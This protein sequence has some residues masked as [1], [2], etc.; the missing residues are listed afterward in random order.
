M[1][2]DQAYQALYIIVLLAF[3]VMIGI[4]LIR[5]V[6]TKGVMERILCVNMLSTMVI[7]SIA[8][9]ARM[10]REPFL[11]DV[12]LIY[13]MISFVAVLMLSVTHIPPGKK[14]RHRFMSYDLHRKSGEKHDR[15]ERRNP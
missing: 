4:M 6:T 11:L 5:S 15:A 9:L 2:L 10:L 14:I 1:S 13:A 8:V 12:A 3:S 7:S